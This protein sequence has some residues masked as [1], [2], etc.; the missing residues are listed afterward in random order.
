MTESAVSST[1]LSPIP[2]NIGQRPKSLEDAPNIFTAGGGFARLSVPSAACHQARCH[3]R[4]RAGTRRVS[5]STSRR[6]RRQLVPPG[7]GL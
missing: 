4:R 5:R 7:I 6:G 3:R 1:T 2:A